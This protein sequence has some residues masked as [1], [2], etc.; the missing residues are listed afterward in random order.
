MHLVVS[1]R[2]AIRHRAHRRRGGAQRLVR[3]GSPPNSAIRMA[4]SP[5][6]RWS[7]GD[8]DDA[9]RPRARHRRDPL[10]GRSSREAACTSRSR[11]VDY[12]ARPAKE[13]HERDAPFRA[14]WDLAHDVL[15]AE[16]DHRRHSIDDA[17]RFAAEAFEVMSKS[18]RTLIEDWSIYPAAGNPATDVERRA[19]SPPRSASHRRRRSRALYDDGNARPLERDPSSTSREDTPPPSPRRAPS[20][21]GARRRRKRARLART[22]HRRASARAFAARNA[23]ERDE[24]CA[25]P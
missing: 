16:I 6:A 8:G 1:H 7:F 25:L 2:A 24:A 15:F 12:T 19:T 13:S 4:E 17:R 22:S 3:R 14:G 20:R 5:G 10:R 11:S 18:F 9:R 23:S 21:A